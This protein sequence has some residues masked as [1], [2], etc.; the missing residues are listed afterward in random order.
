MPTL[1]TTKDPVKQLGIKHAI[2]AGVALTVISAALALMRGPSEP[3]RT[4]QIDT[5]RMY[6]ADEWAG[7]PE[8]INE[9]TGGEKSKIENSAGES[10]L[11]AP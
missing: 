6:T 1:E 3:T 5:E 9:A 2:G 10:V 8:A 7:V 11:E 4:V